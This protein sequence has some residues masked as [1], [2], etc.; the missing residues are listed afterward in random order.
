MRSLIK[1]YVRQPLADIQGPV[2]VVTGKSR[3]VTFVEINNDINSM[4]DIAKIADL[5]SYFFFF[6]Y[7]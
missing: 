4:I 6:F 2:T 5:A 3:R 7:F 1:H